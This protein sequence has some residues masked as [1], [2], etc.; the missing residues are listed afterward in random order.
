M[1][2][3]EDVI[4]TAKIESR[5]SKFPM[6]MFLPCL[7]VFCYIFPNFAMLQLHVYQDYLYMIFYNIDDKFFGIFFA[8]KFIAG[9]IFSAAFTYLYSLAERRN[10]TSSRLCLTSSGLYGFSKRFFSKKHF[11]AEFD[12]I[13]DIFCYSGITDHFKSC[14][15]ICVLYNNG[16]TIEFKNV[17]DAEEFVL[18]CREIKDQNNK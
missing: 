6:K 7:F 12:D 14:Q 13:E 9:L 8:V 4:C 16:E 3:E 5:I 1:Y 10:S 11:H 15:R 2:C 18:K 17:Y